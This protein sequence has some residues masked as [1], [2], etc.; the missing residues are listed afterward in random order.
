MVSQSCTALCR[1]RLPAF[2]TTSLSFFLIFLSFPSYEVNFA[3][4]ENPDQ[5][6]HFPV[7][8]G[9]ASDQT[10][11]LTQQTTPLAGLPLYPPARIRANT[12]RSIWRHGIAGRIL[13]AS[14]R[15]CSGSLGTRQ[16][17][18]CHSSQLPWGLGWGPQTCTQVTPFV[19]RWGWALLLQPCKQKGLGAGHR[20]L[21]AAHKDLKEECRET[22]P[23]GKLPCHPKPAAHHS[24]TVQPRNFLCLE[25]ETHQ[26]ISMYHENSGFY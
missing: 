1:V 2:Q 5:T 18:I 25:I 6:P 3:P 17:S 8:P 26:K 24:P 23:P 22:N 14:Q 16:F 7:R 9:R 19:V 11:Q 10:E 13:W 4:E 15:A 21:P 20:L 12:S